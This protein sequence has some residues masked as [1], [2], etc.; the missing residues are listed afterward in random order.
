MTSHSVGTSPTQVETFSGAVE[1]R[2]WEF[3]QPT[4]VLNLYSPM[5]SSD[6]STHSQLQ[7]LGALLQQS[8]NFISLWKWDIC[9]WHTQLLQKWPFSVSWLKKMMLIVFTPLI[10][11]ICLEWKVKK[12]GLIQIH[13][14][15]V[16]MIQLIYF[17]PNLLHKIKCISCDRYLSCTVLCLMIFMLHNFAS[18]EFWPKYFWYPFYFIIL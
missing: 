10:S 18:Y 14:Y 5:Q 11:K 13:N 3:P 6:N 17:F 4:Q 1:K 9:H 15:F 16:V 7:T 8:C 12:T 2:V